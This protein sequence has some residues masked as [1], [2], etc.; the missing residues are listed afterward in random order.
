[1][2]SCKP[3][4]WKNESAR[5]SLARRGIKTTGGY[6]YRAGGRNPSERVDIHGMNMSRWRCPECYRG[7]SDGECAF[8]G[9]IHTKPPV[10]ILSDKYAQ[11]VAIDTRIWSVL[12]DDPNITIP[13][14]A[15]KLGMPE[16]ILKDF[17][18]RVSEKM[19]GTTYL[20]GYREVYPLKIGRKSPP[21]DHFWEKTKTYNGEKY[22]RANRDPI[23]KKSDAMTLLKSYQK[24]GHGAH[25]EGEEGNWIIYVTRYAGKGPLMPSPKGG[26]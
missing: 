9:R 19:F 1:M 23:A 26:E 14:L 5:H 17:M 25:L 8:H 6:N 2:M 15:K 24:I 7:L 13:G 18:N 22:V 4:G 16:P 12:K 21:D 20:E 10:D 11:E 3:P